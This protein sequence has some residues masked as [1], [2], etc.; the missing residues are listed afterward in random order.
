MISGADY[1]VVP[2]GPAGIATQQTPS[3][4]V[5]IRSAE[6][7]VSTS[8]VEPVIMGHAPSSGYTFSS[9]VTS[10]PTGRNPAA[11]LIASIG[12]FEARVLV[13]IDS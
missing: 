5:L 6:L 8:V 9:S 11:M 10:A 4:S 12:S 2:P 7:H 3:S 13:R 1:V